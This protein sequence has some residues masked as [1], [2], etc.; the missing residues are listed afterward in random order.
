LRT[1]TP[2]KMVIPSIS[3]NFSK[4]LKQC[5]TK[6]SPRPVAPDIHSH[7]S[8]APSAGPGAMIPSLILLL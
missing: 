5:H 8:S 7:T 4:T 6:E 3:R 2:R 1:R